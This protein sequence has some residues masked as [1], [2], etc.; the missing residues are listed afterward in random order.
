MVAVS[1][2]R[3]AMIEPGT[4]GNRRCL[5]ATRSDDTSCPLGPGPGPQVAA[6][7]GRDIDQETGQ[8]SPPRAESRRSYSVATASSDK[9]TVDFVDLDEKTVRCA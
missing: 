9:I 6:L 4:E 3:V 8:L 2:P 5:R 1:A 7:F